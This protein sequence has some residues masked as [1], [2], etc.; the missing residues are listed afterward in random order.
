[1]S[2]GIISLGEVPYC[3]IRTRKDTFVCRPSLVAGLLR[4]A[5]SETSARQLNDNRF[6]NEVSKV[7]QPIL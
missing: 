5:P 2:W 7:I 4:S 3:L 1:M 6:Y